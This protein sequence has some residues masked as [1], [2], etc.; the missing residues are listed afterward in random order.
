MTLNNN[1][2][3]STVDLGEP[4]NNIS[5]AMCEDTT[6]QTS[7][8]AIVK[9]DNDNQEGMADTTTDDKPTVVLEVEIEESGVNVLAPLPSEQ[10]TFLLFIFVSQYH[11]SL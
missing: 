9:S 2:S 3:S 11:P 7:P 10:K 5:A 8:D 4:V 6:P 1:D